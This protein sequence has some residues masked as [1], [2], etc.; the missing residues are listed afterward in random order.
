MSL[1]C[2]AEQ[3]P[4]ASLIVIGVKDIEN[5]NSALP[6][7]LVGQ[8]CA[9]YASKTLAP[10]YSWIDARWTCSHASLWPWAQDV[11]V[12]RK[13]VV[14]GAV[15]GLVR[16]DT[17]HRMCRAP[18]SPWAQPGAHH[19]TYSERIVLPEPVPLPD[20]GQQAVPFYLDEATTRLVI[21]AAADDR[22]VLTA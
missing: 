15:V 3:Q 10:V 20:G 12:A 16:W 8:W 18:C 19:W 7:T 2:L 21:A 17:S 14:R 6:A 13:E 11:K 9:I 1:A 5:R 22:F 4:F